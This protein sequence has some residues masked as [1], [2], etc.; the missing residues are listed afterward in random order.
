MSCLY[1]WQHCTFLNQHLTSLLKKHEKKRQAVVCS[2]HKERAIKTF[3]SGVSV[4]S[5]PLHYRSL[6]FHEVE[7]SLMPASCANKSVCCLLKCR[8]LGVRVTDH[9]EIRL[10]LL[11]IL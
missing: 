2:T 7:P 1:P 4:P 3:F 5:I 8:V 11:I 9:E 6:A 10:N